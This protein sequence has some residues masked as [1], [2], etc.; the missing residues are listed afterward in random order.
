MQSYSIIEPFDPLK[1]ASSC[2]FPRH[3]IAEKNVFL[4]EC[5]K[6]TLNDAIIPAISFAAHTANYT[7]KGKQR[8]VIVTCVLTSPVRMSN[9]PWV[10]LSLRESHS[11]P[12]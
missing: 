5:P 10:G 11:E 4:F 6:E 8:L 9:K 12:I 7:V 1:N 2:L 3:E